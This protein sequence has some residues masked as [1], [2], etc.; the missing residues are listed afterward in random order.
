VAAGGDD[1]VDASFGN[2]HHK[3]L[4]LLLSHSRP[5]SSILT[6]HTCHLQKKFVVTL[7]HPISAQFVSNPNQFPI[8]TKL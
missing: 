6:Y 5:P 8:T 3:H 7:L 1:E 2:R 4:L